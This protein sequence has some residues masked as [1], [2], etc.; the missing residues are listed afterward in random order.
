MVLFDPSWGEFDLET[1]TTI[2]SVFGGPSDSVNYYRK[3]KSEKSRYKKYNI[4]KKLNKED[5]NLN[6][7]FKLISQTKNNDLDKLYNIY[8]K[9][10]KSKIKDWL[11]KYEFLEKT[12]CNLNIPWIKTIFNDLQKLS[13]KNTDLSRAIKR[14]L[15]LFS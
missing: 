15:K 2:S 13:L 6:N 3:I 7:F 11:I 4:K 12:N 14:S 9:I 5:E 10:T 8:E 1:G